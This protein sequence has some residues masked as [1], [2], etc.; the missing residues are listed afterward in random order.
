MSMHED[1]KKWE[2]PARHPEPA[3]PSVRD[4]ERAEISIQERWARLYCKAIFTNDPHGCP[5]TRYVTLPTADFDDFNRAFDEQVRAEHAP[6]PS[7]ATGWTDEQL[8]ALL[9]DVEKY[10][11]TQEAA[12]VFLEGHGLKSDAA[13]SDLAMLLTS[14]QEGQHASVA[15]ADEIVERCA[16]VAEVEASVPREQGGNLMRTD[17]CQNVARDI[18]LLKGT[19]ACQPDSLIRCGEPAGH[20]I[21]GASWFAC[22]LAKGHEGEHRRGGNCFKHGEYVGNEC[23]RWPDCIPQPDSAAVARARLEEAE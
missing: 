21:A 19:F 14:L 7:S 5:Y 17:A 22:V 8:T 23:P 12:K 18:R 11:R 20:L 4:R 2:V 16:K 15:K 9:E 1:L 13:N 6:P 10:S 3:A